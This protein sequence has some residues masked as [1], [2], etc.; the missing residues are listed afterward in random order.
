[1]RCSNKHVN[2]IHHL[3][4]NSMGLTIVIRRSVGTHGLLQGRDE[5]VSLRLGDNLGRVEQPDG[6]SGAGG[7]QAAGGARHAHY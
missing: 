1:M 7:D 3:D 2:I 4:V 5:P 6:A